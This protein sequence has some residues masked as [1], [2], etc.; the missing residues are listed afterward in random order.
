MRAATLALFALSTCTA[1][2]ASTRPSIVPTTA[3]TSPKELFAPGVVHAIHLRIA[4]ASWK[5]IQPNRAENLPRKPTAASSTRP[6][7]I[8]GQHLPPG[9][10]GFNFAYVRTEME[11]DGRGVPDVGVR[12]KGNSSYNVSA[13]SMR[14]PMKL[15]FNRFVAGG[16]FAGVASL[17]LNSA[18]FDPSEVRETIGFSLFQES[19]VPSP[20][21]SH[22]LV[23][24]TVP[25]TF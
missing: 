25:G 4:P 8:E 3:P 10:A 19:G 15:D 20:R 1:L 22:A 17:N 7:Y 21:T 13:A 6:A 2:G 9:P 11:F 14:R 24:L 5:L 16:R 18:V 23:Y 12:F